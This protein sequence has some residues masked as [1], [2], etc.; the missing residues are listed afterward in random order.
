MDEYLKAIY[1]DAARPGSYS[2]VVKLWQAVKRDGNPRKLKFR[3]VKSWLAKQYTYS[4][5]KT[6]SDK[7]PREKII[8][9]EIN[10][11]VDTD[12]MDMSKFSRKND[13]TKYLAVFIDLFSRFLRV[14]PM[15]TKTGQD[16]LQAMKRAID[17]IQPK[18]KTMRSDRGSEYL[19]GPV[20]EYL[21]AQGINHI[22]TYNVYHA[23]Y[24][25]RVIRTIKSK[26]HR[27]MTKHQ[28][29]RYIDSLQDIVKS[30]NDSRHSSIGTAPSQVTPDNQQEL[31]EKLYLP[32]ELERENTEVKYRF[33]IGDKVRIAAARHP[34]KKG[35]DQQWTEE[36]FIVDK[37]V[38][39]HP[40]RYHLIDQMHETIRG[41]YYEQELQDANDHDGVFKVEKVLR[42]RIKDGKRQALVLWL[43]YP[44]KFRSWIDADQIL[45]YE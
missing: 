20:Q 21:K 33:R 7:F 37:R 22:V 24:A 13:G 27:F 6:F 9:G 29:H 32:I 4:M 2:G 8:V 12:L 23:N 17:G 31:Y 18:I 5:H 11:I 19:A 45:D 28:S 3:D 34:F 25:E 38:A 41:T 40:P 39:S 10:E 1:Y 42:Y 14:E 30:Y 35:H 36:I 15:R 44:E 43:G 16:M 26:I